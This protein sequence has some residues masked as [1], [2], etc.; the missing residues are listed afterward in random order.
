[1]EEHTRVHL[2]IEGR[3]Q[4]VYYR[5]SARDQAIAL[6]LTGWVKNLPDRT[7]EAVVEGPRAEVE[8]FTIWC[9]HGPP[10]AH[11][12]TVQAR[13]SAYTGSFDRFFVTR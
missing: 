3:V 13:H 4:G 9:H 10:A 2:I 8:R 6:G 5:A 11:V 12:T 7:V 1:M